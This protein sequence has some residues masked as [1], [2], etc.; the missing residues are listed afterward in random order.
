MRDVSA[1]PKGG[2]W[3]MN[4]HPDSSS[5][6]RQSSRRDFLTVGL[7]GAVATATLPVASASAAPKETAFELNEAR[8][9]TFKSAC[10]QAK[11]PHD[12]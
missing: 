12:P 8:L 3:S 11:K 5:R 6:T 10:N 1:F 9:P 4:V 7:S 2:Q